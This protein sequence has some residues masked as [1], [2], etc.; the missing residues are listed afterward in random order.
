MPKEVKDNKCEIVKDLGN[1]VTKI[2]R[3]NVAKGNKKINESMDEFNENYIRK[4]RIQRF[5]LPKLL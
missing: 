4:R 5:L 1:S 3:E 2:S